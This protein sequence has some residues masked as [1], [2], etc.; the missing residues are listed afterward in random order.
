MRI[1]FFGRSLRSH[2]CLKSLIDNKRN[3]VAVYPDRNDKILLSIC[4]QHKIPLIKSSDVNS[5]ESYDLIK[6]YSPELMVFCNLTQIVN[7]KILELASIATINLHGAKLPEYRGSSVINW[8]I[9]NGEKEG[10]VSILYVDS[11]IDTGEL[12]AE[13]RFE[14][15]ASDQVSDVIEKTLEIFPRLLNQVIEDFQKG[16]VTSK[17]LGKGTIYPHRN[18]ED[19]LV[20]CAK[21]NEEQ[22]YNFVRALNHPLPGAFIYCGGKKLIIWESSRVNQD[23]YV[24]TMPGKIGEVDGNFYLYLKDSFLQI[25]NAQYHLSESTKN[26]NFLRKLNIFEN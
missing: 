20:D 19:G 16:K 13:E 9:I 8:Q 3:V 25:K 21:M 4:E 12:I 26:L 7:T 23:T 5:S 14:I 1:I 17:K 22:V 11:G 15:N 18:P 6:S 24:E 10:G 2:I